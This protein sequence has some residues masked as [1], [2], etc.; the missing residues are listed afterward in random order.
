VGGFSGGGGGRSAFS[1]RPSMSSSRSFSAPRSTTIV[2]S[3]PSVSFGIMPFMP[4]GGWGWGMGGGYH[5]SGNGLVTLMLLGFLAWT[6]VTVF[7]NFNGEAPAPRCAALHA[8]RR[9]EPATRRAGCW[10]RP[11]HRPAHD[12][13]P[14]PRRPPPTQAAARSSPAT[15]TRTS[16]L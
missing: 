13:L 11:A 8:R 5:S 2:H 6:A 10:L 16:R 9:A 3:T 14:T 15:T 1:A 4:F 12:V 7:S